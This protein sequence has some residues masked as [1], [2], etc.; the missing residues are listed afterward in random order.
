MTLPLIITLAALFGYFA[1]SLPFG[2]V[3]ARFVAGIDIRREGSGNIGA[4]NIGRVLGKKWGFVV[5]LL[6]CLKGLLPALFAPLLFPAAVAENTCHVQVVC[7]LATIL[8]HMFPFWLRF[9]GG[10]GVATALGVAIA[11][12][13]WATAAAFVV[14]LVMFVLFRIMSLSSMSAAIAFAVAQFVL[15]P[16]LFSLCW[17]EAAFS[18]LVPALILYRHRSNLLRLFHGEEPRF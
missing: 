17:S 10:K 3:T 4:T 7:G 6:D 9:R 2:Y 15:R 14:F 5:L 11:L 12:S 13:P 8:G 16:E 1:G 18:L